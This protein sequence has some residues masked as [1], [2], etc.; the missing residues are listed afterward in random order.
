MLRNPKQFFI[1]KGGF[2]FFAKLNGAIAGTFAMLKE[3]DNVYEL[4][5]MAVHE[6]YQGMKTDNRM[7]EFCIGHL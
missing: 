6:K 3:Q 2:I 1:D 5:K 7:M 4:S